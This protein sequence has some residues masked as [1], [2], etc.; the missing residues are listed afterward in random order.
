MSHWLYDNK[1][2]LDR[3]SFNGLVQAWADHL[4]DLP[5]MMLLAE[6]RHHFILGFV[7]AQLRGQTVLLPSNRSAGAL[8]EVAADYPDCYSLGEAANTIDGIQTIHC[9]QLPTHASTLAQLPPISDTHTAALVFTSGSTGKPQANP[10]PWHSLVTGA[11]LAQQRFGF[12]SE[13]SIVATVPPQHM[14]GLETT[15]MVP[16]ISGA[17][18]HAGRPFFPADIANALANSEGQRVLITTPIHLRACVAAGLEWPQLEQIICATAPLPAELL[19]AAEQ[20]LR[21]PIREIYGCTEAGSLA[22]RQPAT[23]LDWQL[24]D[25]FSIR[26]QHDDAIIDAPHLDAPVTLSDVI[27]VIDEHSFRLKGRK[28][29]LLNIAGKRASLSDLNLKLNALEGIEDAV[30]FMPDD[31]T[32]N[33]RAR[34]AAFVV[35]PGM[36]ATQIQTA[37]SQQIDAAFLPR[38]LYLVERLPRNETG[39]L[40]RQ[41]LLDLLTQRGKDTQPAT[42]A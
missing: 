18:I 39:K 41:A 25:S 12:S 21:A 26:Q 34:L 31:D 14:Y 27:D 29:D 2:N 42:D 22:S 9:A 10:K 36:T 30:I 28:S 7:A 11:H 38:P 37:L 5:Y 20:C 4:P 23:S 35:A 17:R 1:L 15:V 3:T 40:P 33:T 24:Y 8:T 16:L 6:Q 32:Q 19:T 13:H